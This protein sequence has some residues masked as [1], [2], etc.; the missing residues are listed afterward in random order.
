MPVELKEL[1]HNLK[2]RNWE[3]HPKYDIDENEA[4]KYIK[5]IEELEEREKAVKYE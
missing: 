5:A 2:D 1:L 4:R 3:I